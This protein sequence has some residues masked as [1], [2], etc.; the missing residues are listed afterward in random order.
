NLGTGEFFGEMAFLT[1][2]PRQTSV[3]AIDD[4]VVAL[5][6]DQ[7]LMKRLSA[8]IREKVKDQIITKLIERLNKT[9]ERL[10]VRM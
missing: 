10:R 5:Q 4:S 9:T 1:N 6:V 7:D 3:V 2:E 8:E